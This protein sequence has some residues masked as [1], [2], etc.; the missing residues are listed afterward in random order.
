MHFIKLGLIGICSLL[1]GCS[2]Y[3]TRQARDPYGTLIGMS[4]PDLISC[5][6]VPDHIQQ[7][8]ENQAVLQWDYKSEQPAFKATITILGSIEV[9]NAESCKLVARVLR[10]GTTADV[11]FPGS[12]TTLTGGPHAGC[13]N[14]ISECL[15]HPS[16]TQTSKNYD[17]FQYLQIR[18]KP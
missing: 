17:A 3:A 12:N 6:G 5:A 13:S 11:A 16:T 10:D 4:M 9:G 1:M 15:S 18:M 14:I 2:E 8:D 7:L